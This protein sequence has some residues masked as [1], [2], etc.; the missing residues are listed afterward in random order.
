MNRVGDVGFLVGIVVLFDIVHS[1]DISVLPVL[2]SVVPHD[3]V[4]SLNVFGFYMVK[5]LT[6]DVICF[7]L[8]IGIIGKSA[9]IGLH[10]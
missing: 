2:F 10:T 8:F 5:V 9:Q 3:M 1:V 7:F 6:V 4:I